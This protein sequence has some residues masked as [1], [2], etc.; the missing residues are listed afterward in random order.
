MRRRAQGVA[1]AA[2]MLVAGIAIASVFGAGCGGGDRGTWRVD[3]LHPSAPLVGHHAALACDD[4]HGGRAYDRVPATCFDCHRDDF[5]GSSFD[6]AAFGA[7]IECGACHTPEGWSPAGFDHDAFGFPLL[8]RHLEAACGA[9]HL[10]GAWQGQPT[11]C[12][13]CHWAR[14]Q[15]DPWRLALGAHCEDCHTEEGWPGA[16]FDHLARTGFALT[17]AHASIACVECHPDRD[18]SGAATDCNACHAPAAQSAGHPA[19]ATDC[20]SCHTTT[21]WSPSSF[22]H[23]ALFPIA[24]GSH[25][26]FACTYCHA[27]ATFAEFTCL[28]CHT[29]SETDPRHNEVSGYV[30]E[31][32]ACYECH[33]RGTG[34]DDR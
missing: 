7:S 21:A 18:P 32:S 31:S 24:R 27:G 16:P 22:D 17:G 3:A 11:E 33:P 13:D 34:D 8:G 23:E 30:Y 1:L 5:E 28:T 19:F 29:R 6:H 25:S 4:C 20:S 2:V 10:D 15:D 26:G 9:C 12:E 14:S